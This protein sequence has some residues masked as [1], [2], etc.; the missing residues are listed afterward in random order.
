MTLKRLALAGIEWYIYSK[1]NINNESR[2][3]SP[4]FLE[5]KEWMY[6]FTNF[7]V[8]LTKIL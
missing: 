8:C 6:L 7:F 4:Y 3:R 1:A 2:E 5:Y